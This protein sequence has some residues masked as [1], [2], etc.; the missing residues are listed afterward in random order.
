MKQGLVAFLVL[1]GPAFA[2][3]PDGADPVFSCSLLN[4]DDVELCVIGGDLRMQMGFDLDDP[5]LEISMPLAL[6]PYMSTGI[7][8]SVEDFSYARFFQ[9]NRAYTVGLDRDLD[10][11]SVSVGEPSAYLPDADHSCDAEG[12]ID[13]F[14]ALD[15]MMI[16]IGRR[17]PVVAARPVENVCGPVQS[18]GPADWHDDQ[19]VSPI[20][21]QP[22][23][24]VTEVLAVD[25][26]VRVCGE[27]AGDW[28]PVRYLSDG[29]NCSLKDPDAPGAVCSS[30][31]VHASQLEQTET[32]ERPQALACQ[33]GGFRF[34][35]VR[36]DNGVVSL[37]NES[38]S[39][40]LPPGD[41]ELSTTD[42]GGTQILRINSKVQLTIDYQALTVVAAHSDQ[43]E[44]AGECVVVDAEEISN[45]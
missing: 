45:K 43:G 10:M 25:D 35:M 39:L 16:G 4:S 24:T 41:G 29:F 37:M 26:H 5:S 31:W 33:A 20:H 27:A 2:E 14:P 13:N 22:K 42:L 17:A 6:M 36:A 9:G 30:G 21:I 19:D 32:D 34:A 23:D 38:M 44:Q 18:L 15:Q 1:A 12:I 11:A 8:K 7:A 3:C 28:Y 40:R